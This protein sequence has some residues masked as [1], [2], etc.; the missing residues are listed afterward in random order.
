MNPNAAQSAGGGTNP[1]L[2]ILAQMQQGQSG[3][4]GGSRGNPMGAGGMPSAGGQ[5]AVQ[6]GMPGGTPTPGGQP[7]GGIPGQQQPGGGTKLLISA[8]QN[9]HSFANQAVDPQEAQLIRQILVLL[10]SLIQK[11]QARQLQG[12]GGTAP[13]GIQPPMGQGAGGGVQAQP[14]GIMG[15]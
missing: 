11:D 6:G 4:I 3:G 15:R 7:A 12:G 9:L 1:F 5:P 2:Q 14:A 13:Q 10:S 8:L